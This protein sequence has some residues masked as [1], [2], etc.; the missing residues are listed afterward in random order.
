[1][2]SIRAFDFTARP[3]IR[4][5][6]S[7]IA[8]LRKA[9]GL[10]NDAVEAFSSYMPRGL[11]RQLMDSGDPIKLGGQSRYLTIFFTDLEGFTTLSETSP[12]R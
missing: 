6:V 10:L 11:V 12:A 4:T 7:E 3:P 2:E 8:E 5:S 9:V 1:M